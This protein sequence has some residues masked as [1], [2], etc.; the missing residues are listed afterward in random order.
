MLVIYL[1]FIKMLILSLW[2][3]V[4]QMVILGFFESVDHGSW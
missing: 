3:T 4:L 2:L 1:L